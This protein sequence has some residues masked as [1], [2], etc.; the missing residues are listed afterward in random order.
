MIPER[1]CFFGQSWSCLRPPPKVGGNGEKE[2]QVED[3]LT[4]E[5]TTGGTQV[6][7]TL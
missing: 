4:I 1:R 5:P 6:A 3:V 7:R 2:E